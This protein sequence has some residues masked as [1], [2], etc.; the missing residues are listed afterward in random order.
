MYANDAQWYLSYRITNALATGQV[1]RLS[2]L[3]E[4]MAA[5]SAIDIDL[6][7]NVL[8]QLAYHGHLPVLVKGMRRAWPNI[9]GADNIVPWGI[10]EFAR[11]AADYEIFYFVERRPS[12]DAI[13]PILV[14][15]LTYY[16]EIDPVRLAHHMELLTGQAERYWTQ[17]DFSFK[18]ADQSSHAA[19]GEEEEENHESDDARKNLFDLSL[20]FV[21]HLRREERV[22]VTKAALASEQIRRYVL[23][24]HAGELDPQENRMAAKRRSKRLKRKGKSVEPIHPLGPDRGTLDRFLGG[25]LVF[26]NPQRYKAAATLEL[27][28]DWLRFLKSRRLIDEEERANTMLNL[29]GLD[30]ELLKI[31]Q[32]YPEDPALQRGLEGWRDK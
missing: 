17:D 19:L 31:W 5:H 15:N 4:E 14:E 2:G 27:M 6:F 32:E 21:G 18:S 7:N 3:V 30:T 1:D 26:I 13:D 25:L 24:R 12:P 23:E 20:E 16:F 10:D 22:P 28:P 29:R 8:D 9:K 11:R